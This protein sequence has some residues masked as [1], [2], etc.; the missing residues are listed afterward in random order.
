MKKINKVKKQSENKSIDYIIP[1]IFILSIIVPIIIASSQQ[2]ITQYGDDVVVIGWAKDHSISDIFTTKLGTGYRP[3]MN[4]F[5]VI[6]YSLWGNNAMGYYLLDGLFL[7]SGMVFLYLLGK[8]LHSRLAGLVA[9]LLYLSLDATF[10]LVEKINFLV[11]TGEILFITSA[12]YYSIKYINTKEKNSMWAAIILSI[13]A[14]FTKEP[15]ILIIPT[16]ILTYLYCKKQLNQKYVVLCVAPFIYLLFEMMFISPD[17]GSGNTSILERIYANFEFYVN[18]EIN[19]QFRTPVLLLIAFIIAAYYYSYKNLATEISLCLV[20]MIV[21]L[22]PFLITQQPVQPTYLAEMNLGVVLLIGI[23]ISEGFKKV[24]V[25][26]GI[27]IVGMLMQ[28]LMIPMQITGMQN[29]NKMISDNQNTFLE[30]V[31]EIKLIPENEP[32]YYISENIKNK[33]GFQM[34]ENFFK[35]YLYIVGINANLT[36]NYSK[37][38][39]IILPSVADIQLFQKE[40]PNETKLTMVKQIQHGNEYGFILKKV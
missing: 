25:I 36:T 12:L 40:Y 18:T 16:V 17:V 11:T 9:V 37:A 32:I 30:T 21:A 6:G 20:W 3:V 22:A 27:L 23:V 5:Y 33:V 29:Y 26:T 14:F 2:Y 34:C 13:L 35:K 19:S 8:I 4:L 38:K 24:D 39:Y 28:L 15:S 31:K 10:I 1:L 7:A